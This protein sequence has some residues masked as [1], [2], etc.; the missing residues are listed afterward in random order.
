MRKIEVTEKQAQ[1]A[2]KD[3]NNYFNEVVP[4]EIRDIIGKDRIYHDPILK[5]NRLSGQ[6]EVLWE[7]GPENWAY[8]F[9][10]RPS[11]ESEILSK[12]A[13]AEFGFKYT[14]SANKAPLVLNN[15]IEFDQI[16]SFAITL[17][18]EDQ[19]KIYDK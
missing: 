17:Y 3:I 7:D 16:Y 13:A 18:R 9:D 12:Q 14:R 19:Q 4:A 8:R 11:E 1:Q 15:G 10:G 5:M 2:V 6:W